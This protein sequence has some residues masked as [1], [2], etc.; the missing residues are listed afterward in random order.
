MSNKKEEYV[1]K[2]VIE[3]NENTVEEGSNQYREFYGK[4]SSKEDAKE[5]FDHA[6]EKARELE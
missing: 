1:I 5:L 6:I 4:S 3:D 2:A